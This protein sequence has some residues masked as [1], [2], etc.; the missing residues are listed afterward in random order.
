MYR[1]Q[2]L[3]LKGFGIKS[4]ECLICLGESLWRH[5]EFS[6]RLG[7]MNYPFKKTKNFNRSKE[8]PNI[9]L[10]FKT[11]STERCICGMK[12]CWVGTHSHIQDCFSASENDYVLR[13]QTVK[14]SSCD[15]TTSG[16]CVQFS[17]LRCS[18]LLKTLKIFHW[19]SQYFKRSISHTQPTCE[20]CQ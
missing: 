19:L 18:A 8:I 20:Q 17:H 3:I 1:Y 6:F 16:T 2:D 5:K 14:D 11:L 10:Q 15:A 13:R 12:R 4:N 9:Y 7:N